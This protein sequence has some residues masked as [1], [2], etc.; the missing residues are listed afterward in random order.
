MGHLEEHHIAAAADP[1]EAGRTVAA[2]PVAAGHTAVAVAG[3]VGEHRLG[4]LRELHREQP[5]RLEV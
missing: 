3:E 2:G 1:A 4:H 5:E